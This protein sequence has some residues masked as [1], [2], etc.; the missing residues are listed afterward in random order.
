MYQII[1]TCLFLKIF[2]DLYICLYYNVSDDCTKKGEK[3]MLTKNSS[4]KTSFS[5][6]DFSKNASK[7]SEFVKEF[8]SRANKAGKFLNWVNLPQE[9]LKRVDEL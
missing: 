4:V 8:A 1:A 9:Q 2:I 5:G 7:T 3:S 6:V